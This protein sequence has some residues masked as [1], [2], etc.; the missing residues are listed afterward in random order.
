MT[1]RERAELQHERLSLQRGFIVVLAL[2]LTGVFLWMIQN[3]LGALFL[4]AVL[5]IFVFPMQLF[6]SKLLGGRDKIAAGLS[7]L[8]TTFVVLIPFLAIL[9]LVAQQA[10][11]VGQ[12]FVPWVQEQIRAFRQEGFAG[13]PDWLPFRDSLAPYQ[14]E[15]ATRLGEAA[16]RLGEFLVGGLW[17][18]TGGLLGFVLNL[19]ILLFALYYLLTAGPGSLKR[20]LGLLPM[21]ARDRDLL[22][23]RALSTIRATVKGSFI[24]ALVQGG[25]TGIAMAIAG[26]PGAAFWG[27]IAGLLSIIPG[28]GPPIVWLPASIWL[29]MNGQ[30]VAGIALAVWGAAVVGVIDN[31]LRPILVGQDAKMSDLMV[32]LSTLGGLT[33]FGAMGII[34]GPVIAALFTSAWFI[35]AKSF[36]GLLA[37]PEAAGESA[38]LRDDNP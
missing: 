26:V 13:L 25:L 19:V 33:L 21:M 34:I 3:Y 16:S 5:A 24:I 23:E 17:R 31:I 14:T 35:Y 12:T 4:A 18:A 20:G 6:F 32:L 28:V 2:S 22:A 8:V 1:E 29:W 9:V 37:T 36:Q 30:Q 10:V 11:D 38:D 7:L 15:I 27:A